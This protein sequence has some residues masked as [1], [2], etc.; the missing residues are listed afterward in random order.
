M[1]RE[2]R[3]V[4]PHYKH[5]TYTFKSGAWS[6]ERD[7]AMPDETLE[8]AQ[9]EW[10]ADLAL[11]LQGYEPY[12]KRG[13][14]N[15]AAEMADPIAQ[16]QHFSWVVERG[17][18]EEERLIK[19]AEHLEMYREN[20]HHGQ[21]TTEDAYIEEQGERPKY[22]DPS[23]GFMYRPWKDEEATW[24]QVWQ[25][26]SEGSPT[27]PPF[28]TAEELIEYLTLNGQLYNGRDMGLNLGPW[29]RAAAEGF[30]KAG[31]A[32]TLMAVQKPD[33]SRELQDAS[34]MYEDEI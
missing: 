8:Q 23:T 9:A 29:S 17:G 2:I 12:Y 32:P 33:G 5:P 6:E 18:T 15:Y 21:E 31:W 28:A 25:T 14:D 30:V 13:F 20:M 7:V 4:P 22:S 11:W 16:R 26:V 3:M 10:D 24:I 27:T 34:T 19:E 1:G